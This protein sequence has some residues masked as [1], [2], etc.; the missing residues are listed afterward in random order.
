MKSKEKINVD[1]DIVKE[2]DYKT[3]THNRRWCTNQVIWWYGKQ[4]WISICELTHKLQV[5]YF[6]VSWLSVMSLH[7]KE[8]IHLTFENTIPSGDIHQG[9]EM[10]DHN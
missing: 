1:Q 3:I 4:F 10:Q 8:T 9:W 6:Y 5:K 2:L 7:K